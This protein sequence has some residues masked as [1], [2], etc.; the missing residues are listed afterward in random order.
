MLGDRHGQSGNVDFLE[1]IPAKQGSPH[2]TGDGYYRHGIHIG[3]S[4]SSDQIGRA[5][6]GS[7]DANADL[8][9]SAGVTVRRMR[10]PLFM[11]CQDMTQRSVA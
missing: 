8:A 10:R 1:G 7:G 4:Q 5:G 11:H 3:G 6:T 9:G 2:L